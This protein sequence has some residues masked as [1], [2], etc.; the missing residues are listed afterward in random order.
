V[1][2][3]EPIGKDFTPDEGAML[4]GASI[5]TVRMARLLKRWRMEASANASGD[6]L[7][8]VT[9]TDASLCWEK[10]NYRLLEAGDEGPACLGDVS[11]GGLY[12]VYDWATKRVVWRSDWADAL[13]TPSGF[14]FADDD[15]MYLADLEGANI[16]A[17]D[18]ADRPGRL[19]RRLSH[20]YLN[21]VHSLERTRRGFLVA[22]SGVD[23]ILELDRAGQPLWEWWAAEHG[24]TTTPSGRKR[25]AGR[26]REH[27]NVYYHTRYHA[28]HVN[29]A[30]FRDE[31]EQHVLALLFHQGALV[32]ID[33]SRPPHD[34]RAELVLDGLGKPHGLERI[35]GGWLLCNSL[36]RE[37]LLLDEALRI[38]RKFQYDG[39]WL[40]D[41]T[42]LSNGNILLNDV[43]NHRLVELDPETWHE[44]SV[45][46]YDAEWRMGE[47][48]ELPPAHEG[49]LRRALQASNADVL[50]PA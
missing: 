2:V 15:R 22:A 27:R 13:V 16:F 34:Q 50:T 4:V 1:W 8:G 6:Q 48:L 19:L 36:T 24:Y 39:G 3:A 18:L 45:T 10:E 20:G 33:R 14:C 32:Q 29:A 38:S 47:L 49:R 46:L 9:S 31:T 35:P 5:F 21:D 44:V 17:V 26:G 43:D 23:L 25:P 11:F 30:T 40:Q 12:V 37:V 42:R 7:A 28:T 41:C